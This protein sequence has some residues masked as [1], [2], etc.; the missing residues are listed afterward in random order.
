MLCPPLQMED[1][2][3]YVSIKESSR[4]FG[5]IYYKECFRQR[6]SGAGSLVV[7]E[8]KTYLFLESLL[9]S[10]FLSHFVTFVFDVRVIMKSSGT[11]CGLTLSRCSHSLSA[12]GW[13]MS[14]QVSQN[15]LCYFAKVSNGCPG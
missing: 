6:T 1:D 2:L 5:F 8:E 14:G 4:K 13:I 7:G 9:L 12:A 15:I 11:T 10:H 3:S